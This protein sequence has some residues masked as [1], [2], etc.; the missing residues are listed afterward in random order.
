MS[1]QHEVSADCNRRFDNLER[2]SDDIGTIKE[3]IIQ[4]K[5]HIAF[6]KDDSVK[7]D[8]RDVKRDDRE[9]R[10]DE[11]DESL[12]KAINNINTN[13]TGINKELGVAINRISTIEG[14][15]KAQDERFTINWA[16]IIKKGITAFLL[17]GF[18]AAILYVFTNLI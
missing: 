7:R 9:L 3:A 10:R 5:E 14:R 12:A 13:L 16:D 15:I 2:K 1:E 4:I 11:K 8:V 17:I 18:G 6:A